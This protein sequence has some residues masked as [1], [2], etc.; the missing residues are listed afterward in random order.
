MVD[1]PTYTVH[2]LRLGTLTVDRGGMIYG[3]QRGEII[4]IPV[5]SAAIE[6][7][8]YR[9]LVDTGLADPQRW[10]AYNPCQQLPDETLAAALAE[11]G[12]KHADIDLVVNTHLHYDHCENNPFLPQARFFVSQ[13]EWRY[14]KRPVP[15]QVWS[16]QAPW[17]GPEVSERNYTFISGACYEVL[18]GLQMIS[19]PGHTPGHYSVLVRTA[20][21]VVCVAGDAACL[22]ENLT[23]PTPPAVNVS[24]EESLRSIAKIRASAQQILMNHDPNV[25]KYQSS[26]FPTMPAAVGRTPTV[27]ET[28]VAQGAA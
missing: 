1:L 8:G 26:S 10:S 24:V 21:G 20:Q 9:I 27:V 23:V 12:W 25:R 2:A 7:G 14:A 3:F 13:I 5:W 15:S 6:G 22:M 11:L 4:D 28:A 19:T 17:T 18:P 16:Y